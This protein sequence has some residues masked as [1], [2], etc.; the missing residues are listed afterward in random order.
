MHAAVFKGANTIIQFLVAHGADV[1]AR[2]NMGQTGLTLAELG[3][4]RNAEFKVLPDTAA[5]LRSLGGELGAPG[6]SDLER[7]RAATER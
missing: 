4:Y 1:N 2:N 5:V 3:H 7:T 6:S